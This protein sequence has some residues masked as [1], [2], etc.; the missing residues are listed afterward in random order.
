[1][2]QNRASPLEM[3]VIGIFLNAQVTIT[4]GDAHERFCKGLEGA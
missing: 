4:G 1:M 2:F 3:D